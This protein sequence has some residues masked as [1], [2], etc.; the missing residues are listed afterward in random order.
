MPKF[1]TIVLLCLS[2]LGVTAGSYLA[3]AAAGKLSGDYIIYGG[4]LGDPVP[5]TKDD[6]KVWIGISGPLASDMYRRLGK[7]SELKD[8]CGGPTREK[9]DVSCSLDAQ[10]NAKCYVNFDLRTGEVSGGTIC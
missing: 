7:Q 3:Y 8:S 2:L 1:R 4:G 9:K 10:G 5:P 6:A